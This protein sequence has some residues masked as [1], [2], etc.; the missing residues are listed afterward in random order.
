MQLQTPDLDGSWDFSQSQ[1]DS[2]EHETKKDP[3]AFISML[4]KSYTQSIQK[5]NSESSDDDTYIR[6][7]DIDAH[8]ANMSVEQKVAQLFMFGFNGTNLSSEEE[9]FWSAYN[10]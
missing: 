5:H 9:L 4:K 2:V 7:L 3:E 8:I 1:L 6:E 10:P